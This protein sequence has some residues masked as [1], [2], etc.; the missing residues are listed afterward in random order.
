MCGSCG[1]S[2]AYHQMRGRNGTFHRY[3]YCRN[4]DPVSAGGKHL[5]CQERNIRSEELDAFVF[6]QVRQA[7]LRPEALLAGQHAVAA[8]QPAPD[9]ELLGAQLDRL[10][11]KLQAV[12]GRLVDLYQSGL[13]ELVEPAAPRQGG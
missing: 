10:E 7:L 3:Y 5:R 8:G 6:G 9:D 13:I 4:H 11:R 12:D 2:T 1:V